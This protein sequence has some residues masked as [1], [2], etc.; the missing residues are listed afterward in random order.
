MVPEMQGG[1]QK[2]FDLKS[3][4][5]NTNEKIDIKNI[6]YSKKVYELTK[7]EIELNKKIMKTINNY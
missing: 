1:R 4:Q 5:I 3:T 6:K 7:E 2:G